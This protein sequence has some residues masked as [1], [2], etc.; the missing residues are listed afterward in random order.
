M[1]GNGFD[2]SIRKFLEEAGSSAPTP[3]GGSI[4]VLCAALGASMGSMVANLTTGPKFEALQTEMQASV[5]SFEAAVADFESFL[6]R[7]MYS[8]Q[9]YMDALGMPKSTLEEKQARTAAMQAAAMQAADVPLQLM[10]RCLELLQL[11]EEMAG[12][13]NK[14]VISDLAIAAIA[15]EGAVQS[16]WITVEINLGSIKDKQQRKSREAEGTELAETAEVIKRVVLR[17]V[18]ER[19]G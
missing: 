13:A 7:D 5:K 14:N 1:M 17:K 18:R 11:S 19:I 9:Q 15:L 8:F 10:R 12:K 2:T 16:A 3:G 6:E 4:A